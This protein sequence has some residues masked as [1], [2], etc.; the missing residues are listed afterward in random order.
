MKANV[1]RSEEVKRIVQDT[2]S[3]W[4]RIDVLVNNAGIHYPVDIFE[5]TEEMWDET[6]D[7]NL[8]GTYLC[9]KEVAPIML[10]Q[11]K[12]KIVNISSNSG[13]YH[14]SAM[15]FAEYV[16][17]QSWR[18]WIDKGSRTPSWSVRQCERDLPGRD[19]Y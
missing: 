4:G 16:A 15:R 5:H 18:K 3:A 2:M 11:K 9:S 8:K 13:M 14:P 19:R 1:S 10:N 17:F 7:V 12:G 6:L